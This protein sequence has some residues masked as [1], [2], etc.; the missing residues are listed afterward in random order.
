MGIIEDLKKERKPDSTSEKKL[1]GILYE[2]CLKM[3]K[4]KNK[5]GVTTMTH[6]IPFITVGFPLYDIGSI[7]YKLNG[8]LKKEGF[9]TTFQHPNKIYIKW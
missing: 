9:K 8:M 2:N 7:S 5:H 1:L 6:E 3:I 4:F